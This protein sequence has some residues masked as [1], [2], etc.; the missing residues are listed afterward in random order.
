MSY[1]VTR[2]DGEIV[3]E[4]WRSDDAMP[5][6]EAARLLAREVCRKTVG[7]DC[8]TTETAPLTEGGL[9]TFRIYRQV[10][11]SATSIRRLATTIA[12]TEAGTK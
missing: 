1:I 2:T 4:I 10:G 11:P 5:A 6:N 12:V 8:D 3:S 7:G 9:Y